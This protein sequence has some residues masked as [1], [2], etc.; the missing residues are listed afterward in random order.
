MKSSMKKKRMKI[1][2]EAGETFKKSENGYHISSW[3]KI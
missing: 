2:R 3:C 1:A